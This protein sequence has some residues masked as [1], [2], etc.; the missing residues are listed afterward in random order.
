LPQAPEERS[1]DWV[2]IAAGRFTFG[3]GIDAR[4]RYAAAFAIGRAPVTN[5]EYAEFVRDQ[6]YRP[7]VDW[8]G[9][10]VPTTRLDH[11]VVNV[12]LGDAHAFC[13]WAGVRLPSELEWEKAARGVD[14]RAYPWGDEPPEPRRCNA[15]RT[16][17]GTTPIAECVAGASPYG[18][19]DMAGNVWEW[20]DTPWQVGG[21]HRSTDRRRERRYVVRGG[22]FRDG[23]QFA[24]CCSRLDES[25]TCASDNLGFRVAKSLAQA[26]Y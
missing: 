16:H 1:F 17:A 5:R 4:S 23:C 11:P 6:G 8:G 26:D 19:V 18:C 22:S 12:S 20:T 10:T 7:P 24:R 15:G 9:A 25:E 2:T 13:T 14:G 3:E 21:T